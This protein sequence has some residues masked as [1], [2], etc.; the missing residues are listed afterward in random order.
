MALAVGAPIFEQILGN[1]DLLHNQLFRNI[2]SCLITAI[3]REEHVLITYRP[4]LGQSSI[5]TFVQYVFCSLFPATVSLLQAD[6]TSRQLGRPVPLTPRPSPGRSSRRGSV[7]VSDASPFLSNIC[8]VESINEIRDANSILRV[9]KEL[10]VTVDDQQES[11]PMPFLVIALC[12]ENTHLPRSVAT[13]FS[14]HVNLPTLPP[15]FPH[16]NAPLFEVYDS[17]IE[18]LKSQVFTHKEVGIYM[19]KLIL[20]AD[21]TPLVTSYIEVK[22]KLLLAKSIE[23]CAFLHGRD[24][25]IPDDVQGMFPCLVTHRWLLPG[26]TTFETCNRFAQ[27]IIEAVEV[28]V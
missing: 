25:V 8:I 23:D 13:G 2:V 7:A 18:A 6:G 12:P 11:V 26:V 16:V 5:S 27:S 21:C 22:T 3:K 20:R 4:S 9:M 10:S 24:F 1:L 14:F 28:P 19:G 17:L 15:A